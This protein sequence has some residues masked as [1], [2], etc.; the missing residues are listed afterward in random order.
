MNYPDE[1]VTY[2]KTVRDNIYRH[3]STCDRGRP[4]F[5]GITE[6]GER[7]TCCCF[8]SRVLNREKASASPEVPDA[9]A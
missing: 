8:C 7:L 6:G 9:V 4:V 1:I 5:I 2:E 3:C